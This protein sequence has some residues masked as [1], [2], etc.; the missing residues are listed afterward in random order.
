MGE[1]ELLARLEALERRIAALETGAPHSARFAGHP[2]P[3]IEEK[4]SSRFEIAIVAKCVLIVG[5]AYVL[6][7]LTETHVLPQ[8]VGIALGFGYA[9]FW[10]VTRTTFLYIATGGLIAAGLAWET[11]TRFHMI[12]AAGGSAFVAATAIAL[13]LIALRRSEPMIA[14]VAV[15]VTVIASIGIALGTADALPAAITVAAIGCFIAIRRSWE[16]YLT[17]AIAAASDSILLTL[18]VLTAINRTPHDIAV[19]QAGLLLAG[20][21]WVMTPS[22]PQAIIAMVI[23]VGGSA[24]FVPAR[25]ASLVVAIAAAIV[26]T[27]YSCWRAHQEPLFAISAAISLATGT[28]LATSGSLLALAWSLVLC[29]ILA[30]RRFELVAA[31]TVAVIFTAMQFTPPSAWTAL[32]AL[33]IAVLSLLSARLPEAATVARVLLVVAGIKVLVHDLPNAQATT[34]VASLALYGGAMLMFAQRRRSNES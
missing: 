29:A 31:T 30:S 7:A 8:A 21:L 3:A 15:G 16:G 34:L 13:L 26:A 10:I 5:G 22:V 11:A 2:L 6:R 17:T 32:L 12:G 33:G 20:L 23:A 9:L 28:L 19:V 25:G 24:L 18:V 27:A 4:E 14:I 1:A